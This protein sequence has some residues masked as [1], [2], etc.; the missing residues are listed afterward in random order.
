MQPMLWSAE[1]P[2]T[3]EHSLQR[4]P[5]LFKNTKGNQ[6]PDVKGWDRNTQ[7][8]GWKSWSGKGKEQEYFIY[9]EPKR[10]EEENTV[11]LFKT[12]THLVSLNICWSITSGLVIASEVA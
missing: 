8:R 6:P 9:L 10:G 5:S 4:V 11:H 1:G 3:A 7:G 2:P 12:S